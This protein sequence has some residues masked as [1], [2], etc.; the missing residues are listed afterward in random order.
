MPNTENAGRL[1]VVSGPSGSGKSTLCREAVKR[2][3]AQLSISATTRLRGKNEIDGKDYFFLA[4]KDF[5]QKVDEGEFLEHARVFG[6]YY[7]TPAQA[8]RQQ[9]DQGRNVVL[10]IDVQGAAQVFASRPNAV[11]I[12]VLSPDS[13]EL[14]RRLTHRGRDSTDV[15]EK[16]LQK[17]QQEVEQAQADGHY[18]HTIVNDKLETAIQELVALF[19]E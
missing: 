12:L 3:D 13:E 1:F 8:V 18:K 7:G 15:I 4:E 9:L 16:R 19:N 10:E 2:T 5:L 6:N 17:A 11:G 14:K